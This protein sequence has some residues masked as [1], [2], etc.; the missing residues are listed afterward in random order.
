MLKIGIL[1]PSDI[2]VRRFI[3]ALKASAQAEFAGIACASAQERGVQVDEKHLSESQKKTREIAEQYGARAFDSYEDL[4]NDESIDA[5]YLP[6][7]PALHERWGLCALEHGK[8]VMLEKPST[9]DVLST[10]R[11]VDEASK[12]NLA[13]HENYAFIYHDRVK[14]IQELI[15]DGALGELRNVRAAFGFPYRGESD[16]RYHQS[17]G[18]GAL[19]DCGGYPIRLATL[20]L[21]EN[22]SVQGAML[23]SARDHDVDVYGSLALVDDDNVSAQL[24]FGMDN[25][26][27]CDLEIWGSL[28]YLRAD[29]I[30]TPPADMETS[31]EITGNTE[32]AGTY[33]CSPCDQFQRSIEHFVLCANDQLVREQT[34]NQV[35]KQ[36]SLVKSTFE[37]AQ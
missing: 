17:M 24:S 13:L 3:P 6:L 18:G 23:A 28:G 32:A 37:E 9:P 29:R 10:E 4:L 15:C 27:K 21:G 7:P 22:A 1:S 31:I 16:F 34:Y 30:F 26:Y 2:A 20:L 11:L 5:V 33:A 19:L 35:I 25:A 14:R 8:H 36:A 12:R